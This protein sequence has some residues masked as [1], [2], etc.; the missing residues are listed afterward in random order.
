MKVLTK[1]LKHLLFITSVVFTGLCLFTFILSL[2]INNTIMNSQYHQKLLIKNDIYSY[3]NKIIITSIDDILANL[4]T[5]APAASGQ[6]AE[7]IKILEKSTSPEM[8]KMN[9]DSITQQAFQYF[10]GERK[11]LPDSL[12]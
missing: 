7:L 8:I 6:Q 10:R 3:A 2:Y 12:Y 1:I 9:I 5:Q 4:K 11:S